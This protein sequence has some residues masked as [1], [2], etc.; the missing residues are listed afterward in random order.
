MLA[1]MINASRPNR[2]HRPH[3]LG[4]HI[5]VVITSLVVGNVLLI[6]ILVLVMR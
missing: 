2:L 5:A 6:V 4:D 3:W 1:T